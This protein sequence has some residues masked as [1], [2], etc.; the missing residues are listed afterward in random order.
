MEEV[1]KLKSRV[2][3]I[4]ISKG[5]AIICIILGHLSIRSVNK[6][7][8]T[9]H[10]PIFYFIT[11]YF[12]SQKREILEFIKNKARTLL[13]PYYITCIVIIIIGT[14]EGL[15]QGKGF[16]NFKLWLYAALY[17]AGDTYNEPFYIKGIG[18]IWFL[19]ASFWGSVFLRISLEF[20][21]PMRTC[22]VV[23]LFLFGYYSRKL[24]W[25]PLS[26]QAG[27]CATLFMYMG[28]LL[29]KS[30]EILARIPEESR[31]FG[32][33]FAIVTWIFFVKDFKSFWLVH[34]DVG[35]GVVDI[36]GC[37]C[38]CA[39]VMVISYFIDTH[40][41]RIGKVLECFGK[42][43]LLV[44]CIHIIELNLFPWQRIVNLLINGRLAS[45]PDFQQY[46]KYICIIIGKLCMD[47][48]GTF[49]LSK[50]EFVR[51]LMGYK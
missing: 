29:H 14:I 23:S 2:S 26:I 31:G 24:F 21:R 36:F 13:V 40:T 41:H 17:A 6:V 28:Y 49:V 37:I 16:S 47:L 18:A 42:Y 39:V 11:G 5:I 43:S 30:V 1:G 34:C 4:D 50:S 27:A 10:V 20:K 12:T 35:R 32:L 3:F 22:F 9:F 15:Q 45:N 19:W 46:F 8:F 44:L 51:K 7:V 33:S 38:A 48:G 25:F